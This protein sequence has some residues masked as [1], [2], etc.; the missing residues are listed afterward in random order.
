MLAELNSYLGYDKIYTINLASV[1]MN[2]L[3]VGI[4]SIYID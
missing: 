3:L 2:H 4:L 1:V